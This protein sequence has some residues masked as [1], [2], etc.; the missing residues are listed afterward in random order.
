M[1]RKSLQTLLFR[2]CIILNVTIST[3]SIAHSDTYVD[4]KL[5]QA[6]KMSMSNPELFST[7]ILELKDESIQLTQDQQNYLD[8]LVTQQ[9][10]FYGEL[11]AAITS[12]KSIIDSDASALLKFR[13]KLSLV[14]IFAHNQNWTEGLSY[15]SK[16]LAELPSIEN[17]EIYQLTLITSSSF[18]N[19]L[20]QY[21]LGLD[22]ANKLESLNLK[23]KN[24]CIAEVLILESR[25]KLKQLL[26]DDPS[27]QQA[28]YI[29]QI[30]NQALPVSFINSYVASIDIENEKPNKAILLLNSTLPA[31][32]N[33]KYPR[34]IAEY[35]SLLAQ[36]Y[37][38]NK[39]IPLTKKFALKAL[40]YEKNT[41]TALPKVMSYKLLYEVA[42]SQKDFE[43]ALLYYQKHAI[44]DKHY[45][46]DSQVKH[47]AFQVAEH[48]SIAQKD[49]INL[50][51]EKNQLLTTEQALISA[52]AENTRLIIMVLILT[53]SVL[54]FWGYRLLKAHKR[55]KQLAEYDDLTGI[56][57][58]RHFSQVARNALRY[59]QSA[60]QE[61]SV[62]MFDLD[63]FK[64]IN[65]TYGHACGDWA[66]K[67]TVR[68]CKSLGRQNDIFAR[69]GGEEFCIL[70]TSCNS[71]TAQ[72]RAEA[73]RQAIADI[74]TTDSGFEFLI[75]ASFGV[76]SVIHSGFDLE[77]LLADADSATYTS[78]RNG[79][80]QVS[81]FQP[82][83]KS[84]L[85]VV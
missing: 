9:L 25:F 12:T 13:A 69:L 35:Y 24:Q 64:K 20:G 63:H 32:L 8:Y 56:F 17:E 53:L 16:V 3:I 2:L 66:L 61:L 85:Y 42:Q 62:I 52:Y 48:K 70:L 75:T 4:Q 44:A 81:L 68:A 15:L 33:T 26:V 22:T 47:L 36:A 50:L 28:I 1:N 72:Q 65:D 82:D 80:D 84:K 18:Y 29:C 77:K 74:D 79:R 71:L 23:G 31:T 10:V 37:W 14:N 43:L 46:N 76:T 59:C 49:K 58:R 38:L 19:Q 55:I 21:Q 27:I 34:I 73:C 41:G 57:N 39:N 45:Y 5:L 7:L 6:D 11:E 54:A 78:K 51:K 83:I 60:K 30:S 67:K 40:E